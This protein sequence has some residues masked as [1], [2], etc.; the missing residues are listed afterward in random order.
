MWTVDFLTTMLGLDRG[1][2]AGGL[3]SPVIAFRL[4]FERFSI[5][6]T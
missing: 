4:Q 1:A 2:G 6:L 5:C 3:H